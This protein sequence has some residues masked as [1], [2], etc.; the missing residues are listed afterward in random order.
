MR[1]SMKLAIVVPVY[2]EQDGLESFYM[3]LRDV[4]MTLN[5]FWQVLFVDDGSEDNSWSVIQNLNT[6]PKS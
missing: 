2:N 3:A 5:Y 4:M 1:T 6:G